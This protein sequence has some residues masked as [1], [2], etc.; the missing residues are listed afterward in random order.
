M[1]KTLT[2]LIVLAFVL[3]AA[4]AEVKKYKR[5]T[6]YVPAYSHIY[7]GNKV[8]PFDLAITLSVR[9]TNPDKEI[10]VDVVDYYD[11]EGKL[12]KAF[13]KEP[14]ILKPFATERYLIAESDRE[15]GSG[16]NFIVKWHSA[17]DVNAPVIEA[18]M[19]GTRSSQGISFSSRGVIIED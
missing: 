14:H 3:Q 5:Q 19:I 15:G 7:V 2:V 12:V 17:Q 8:Q 16:A 18:V 10:S 6:V 9:N 1:K 11:S 4:Y 13:L